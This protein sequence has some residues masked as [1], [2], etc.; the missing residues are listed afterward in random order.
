MCNKFKKLKQ[1]EDAIYQVSND[2]AKPPH[3]GLC[4]QHVQYVSNYFVSTT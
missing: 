2:L 4:I 1:I 3:P